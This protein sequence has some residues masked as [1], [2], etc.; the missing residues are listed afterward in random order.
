MFQ[1][2]A[3][4][5][6]GPGFIEAVPGSQAG[7]A[8]GRSGAPPNVALFMQGQ[9]SGW[10]PPHCQPLRNMEQEQASDSQHRTQMLEYQVQLLQQQMQRQAAQAAC[11][12]Q[13]TTQMAPWQSQT[14]FGVPQMPSLNQYR[15]SQQGSWQQQQ[16]S[17]PAQEPWQSQYQ[18]QSEPQQTCGGPRRRSTTGAAGHRSPRAASQPHGTSRAAITQRDPQ[19]NMQQAQQQ[20]GH[21]QKPPN[22]GNLLHVPALVAG[23]PL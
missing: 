6:I 1:P 4:T 15:T 11:N 10:A 12:Q 9:S 16:V 23:N 2:S 3:T 8:G 14:A 7:P 22:L 18:Q 20:Q 19:M 13:A 5:S 21:T 17:A